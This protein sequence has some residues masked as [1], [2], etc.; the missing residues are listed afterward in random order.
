[1]NTDVAVHITGLDTE[2]VEGV[3]KRGLLDGLEGLA[4]LEGSRAAS[5]RWTAAREGVGSGE[6]QKEC[7]WVQREIEDHV[8]GRMNE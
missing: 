4:A 3:I 5:G 7:G 6:N 1:M 8:G 2:K